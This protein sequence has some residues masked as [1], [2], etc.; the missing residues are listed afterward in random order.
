VLREG[1]ALR[2]IGESAELFDDRSA[3]Q[4]GASGRF[5]NRG[6]TLIGRVQLGYGGTGTTD[7]EGRWNEWHALFDDTRS[8]WLSE[9]NDQYVFVF[10]IPGDPGAP[11]AVQLAP[12]QPVTLAGK[13]WRVASRVQARPLA[14]EGE[15]PSAP[16]LGQSIPIIDLRN[17]Q[18][19]V[20]TLEYGSS[21]PPKLS[22]GQAVRLDELQLKGLR[23]GPDAGAKTLGA[24]GFPCP[25]CGAPIEVKLADTRSISCGNCKSVVDLSKGVGAELTSYRQ[26]QTYEPVIPLGKTGRIAIGDNERRDW[27]V[28]GFSV[29]RGNNEDDSFTWNDYLLYN[30]QEGFAF[31]VDSSEGWVGFRTLT[32]APSEAAGGVSWNGVRY[33]L[34]DS[35]LAEV[36]YVE[37]EFYWKVERAQQT[38]TA[39]FAAGARR[40]SREQTEAE[41]VW[42]Q[43]TTIPAVAVQ[44]AFGLDP[45]NARVNLTDIRPTSG[46]RTGSWV[47][48]LVVII[49][50]LILLSRCGGG[51]GGYYGTSGGSYGGYS[52]GGGHK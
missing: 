29:K 24:Q 49:I 39:D 44:Q 5:Q 22:I 52:S 21:G 2:K 15:L 30:R 18:N 9:D 17:E 3:L 40:L 34:T 14:A 38:R 32:G 1:D 31:L 28:V 36:L 51:G 48:W 19:Q 12:G 42:S 13:Q 46:G 43:G 35:Y 6:F 10:D 41:V 33:R 7:V 25:S 23:E 27:Q 37:G 45:T 16:S 8:G 50:V 20:A 11:P 26:N 47:I 4:L